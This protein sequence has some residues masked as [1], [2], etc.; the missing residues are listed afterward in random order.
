MITRTVK[1]QLAAFALIALVLISVLSAKYVG[2]V[3]KVIGGSYVVS[4]SLAESGGIF[5][6]AEV[7]YRGVTVGRVDALHLER[8]GVRVDARLERGTEVPR[9]T[10]AVVENRSAVGEQYLDLQPR[11]ATGPRLAAGDVIAR[12]RTAT[13][14]R[15]DRL[16][17]HVNATV[18]S[19]PRDALVTTV[20]ELGKAFAGGGADLQ[21]L[22]DSG[23]RLTEAA[24]EA[25]PETIRLIDDGRIVLTTQVEGVKDLTTTVRGFADVAEALQVADPDLR[26]ILDRGAVATGE[27][28]SL[29]RENKQA[30]AA[31]LANF[32][33]IG[34]VTTARLDG[35]EQLLVTYP[36]VVSG[37]YTVLPGDGTAHFGLVLNVDDP[38]A[39]EAGYEGTTKVEPHRTTDL[40]PANLDAHCAAT[41]ASGVNVRGAQNSPRPRPGQQGGA[42]AATSVPVEGVTSG[43]DGSF[44][45]QTPVPD[46][47]AQ[48]PSWVQLMQ[49]AVQ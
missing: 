8:D 19:V 7:T 42:S 10:R 35:I 4:V 41:R 1:L 29:I 30:L 20:D 9:D 12:D 45:V 16:L 3:D 36:E 21:R 37:G 18:E 22:L 47:G 14:V 17:A 24:T 40:P 49:E 39:C 48:V 32:I 25:L 11:T 43:Q 6:G 33:T 28:T 26:V 44:T 5:V 27:L 2:L 34:N 23:D 15:I 46:A 38:P 31:L 13:P